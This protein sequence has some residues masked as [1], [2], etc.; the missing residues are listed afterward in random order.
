MDRPVAPADA[1][2][3]LLEVDLHAVLGQP[4]RL[5]SPGRW[6]KPQVLQVSVGDHQ[7]ILK[8]W[9]TM[10]GWLRPL[11]RHLARREARIY[12]LLRHLET[13]PRVLKTGDRVLVLEQVPGQRISRLRGHHAAAAAAQALEV[14]VA[15]I[16][17]AGVYHFD[18][19]KRD[20]IL[21]TDEGEVYLIDFTTSVAP[22]HYGPLGWLLRPVAA[23]VDRYAVLKWKNVLAPEVLTAGE[24]RLL[25][26][27]DRLRP[28][29]KNH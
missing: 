1:R 29:R 11:A 3:Q 19:R 27:M 4:G 22:R 24:Q 25:R 15:R 21:V 17:A 7:V 26:S 13:I 2:P 6:N 12:G 28:W 5:L 20:N 10:A 18:M 8:D 9:R 16:H 14:I 23:L